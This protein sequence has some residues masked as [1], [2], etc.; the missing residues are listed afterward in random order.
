ML[1]EAFRHL[2]NVNKSVLM[3]ADIDECTE[4][5]DVAHGSLQDHADLQV[6]HIENIGA[7]DRARHLVTRV[8][9]RLLQLFDDIAQR[10]LADT[11]LLCHLLVIF[12]KER[13]RSLADLLCIHI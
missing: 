3:H 10:N 1:D 5:N 11:D 2:G 4:V 8:T 13:R 9:A 7:Q 12:D 6:L